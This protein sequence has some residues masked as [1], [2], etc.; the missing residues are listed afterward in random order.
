M[1]SA[2]LQELYDHWQ[3]AVQAHVEL[4]R[5]GRMHG[6]T[7]AEIDVIGSAYVLRIDAAFARLKQAEARQSNA[8]AALI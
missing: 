1:E 3:S 7:M 6:L 4:I 8:P 2:N 5:N